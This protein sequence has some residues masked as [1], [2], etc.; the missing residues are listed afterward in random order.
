MPAPHPVPLPEAFGLG[1][2]RLVQLIG[3]GGKTTL[4][5]ALARDLAAA[6]RSVLTTTTTRIRFPDPGQSDTVLVTPFD[7][8]LI[9]RLEV[10]FRRHRHVTAAPALL[11]AGHKLAGCGV[12]QLDRLVE[13]R[14]ADWVL[15]EADGAAGRPLKAHAAHEP[16]LS[17]RPGLALAVVGTSCLGQP[18]D[19]LHVHRAALGAER[20]GR[21]PGSAI[22]A[23][24]VAALFF[25]REGYLRRVGRDSEVAVFV[26]QARTA[27][28]LGAA[29]LLAEALRAGDREGRISRIV[30]G[31]LPGGPLEAA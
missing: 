3:A 27:H 29:R 25:H 6:G 8:G 31:D 2:Q 23:G 30:I 12:D 13:A 16:V 10:E 24:D 4:M 9:P 20:L 11:E 14:V 22:T 28:D 18:L 17:G 15:V 21:A 5:F 19:D 26:S 7:S 1:G